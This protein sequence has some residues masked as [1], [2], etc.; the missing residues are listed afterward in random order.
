MADIILFIS[1][2]M[3]GVCVCASTVQFSMNGFKVLES[4]SSLVNRNASTSSQQRIP[5]ASTSSGANFN[6]SECVR[7]LLLPEPTS[8][9]VSMI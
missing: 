5:R 3:Y 9:S 1:V 8:C 4:Q 7:S 6:K 2:C